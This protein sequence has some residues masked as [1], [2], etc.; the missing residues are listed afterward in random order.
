MPARNSIEISFVLLKTLEYLV[1]QF[2]IN[3]CILLEN[4]NGNVNMLK[5]LVCYFD[6]FDIL[7]HIL[8]KVFKIVEIIKKLQ[9]IRNFLVYP[10]F[11][12]S[13]F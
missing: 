1:L 7:L 12:K 8:Y 9:I 4:E 13:R 3:M 5:I 2:L 11:R 6:I 10:K